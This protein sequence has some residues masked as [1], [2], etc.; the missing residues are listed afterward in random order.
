MTE[1]CSFKGTTALQTPGRNL[2]RGI[3]SYSTLKQSMLNRKSFLYP[4]ILVVIVL[5]V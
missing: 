1:C 3:Q 5:G 4:K 2:D